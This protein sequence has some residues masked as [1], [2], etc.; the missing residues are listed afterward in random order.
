MSNRQQRRHPGH[1]V[2][3][4]PQPSGE[5]VSTKKSGK[6]EVKGFKKKIKKAGSAT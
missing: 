3:P 6:T 4:P 5:K 1:P 2:I